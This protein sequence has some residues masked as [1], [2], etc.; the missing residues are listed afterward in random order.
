[1]FLESVKGLNKKSVKKI[2]T[3]FLIIK[4]MAHALHKIIESKYK[5]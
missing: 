1:M 2:F 3:L 5:R 4:K